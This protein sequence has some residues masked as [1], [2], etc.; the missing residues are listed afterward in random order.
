MVNAHFIFRELEDS[1]LSISDF[2]ISVIEDLLMFES[3]K[4]KDDPKISQ[5]L[6]RIE[7]IAEDAIR[8]NKK[9]YWRKNKFY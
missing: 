1:D 4:V 7:N 3:E 2:R 5:R 6:E 9:D 8:R